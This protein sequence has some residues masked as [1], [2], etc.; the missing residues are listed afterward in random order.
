M[1]LA[2]LFLSFLAI[3][4]FS[5]IF[6]APWAQSLFCGLCGSLTWGLFLLFGHL[7]GGSVLSA[8]FAVFFLTILTRFLSIQKRTPVTVYLTT[9]ILPLVPGTGIYY[10]AYHLIMDN[11]AAAA[12]A[13]IDAFKRAGAIT[14][15]IVFGFAIPVR[16]PKKQRDM[17]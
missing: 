15:G 1:I 3:F 4:S 8:L 13:G 17:S 5:V 14:L 16:S 12:S 10:T 9:G 7:G 2:E 11:S 6:H